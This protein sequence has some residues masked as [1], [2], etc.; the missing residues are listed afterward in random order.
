MKGSLLACLGYWFTPKY[1][2]LVEKLRPTRKAGGSIK[3][4]VE[5]SETP[6]KAEKKNPKRAKRATANCRNFSERTVAHFA[7][8]VTFLQLSLGFRFAPPQA[9]CCRPLRGLPSLE[10]KLHRD[11]HIATLNVAIGCHAANGSDKAAGDVLGARRD[12]KVR[13]VKGVKEFSS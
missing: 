3:S 2:T 8:S 5:R 9:L 6:G 4:G 7:G 11:L 12:V 1:T 10:D 13:V